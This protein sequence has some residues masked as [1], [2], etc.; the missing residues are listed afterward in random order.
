MNSVSFEP[1]SE[2]TSGVSPAVKTAS[3]TSLV[4]ELV[5]LR[6]CAPNARGLV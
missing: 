4:V 1:S 3:E 5:N 2:L 6:L